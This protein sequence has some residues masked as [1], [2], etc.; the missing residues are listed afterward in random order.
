MGGG[1]FSSVSKSWAVELTRTTDIAKT[2]LN[3]ARQKN[4]F[5]RKNTGLNPIVSTESIGE[6]QL[7]NAAMYELYPFGATL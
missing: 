3:S 6:G 5:E 1:K 2:S 4:C 7:R